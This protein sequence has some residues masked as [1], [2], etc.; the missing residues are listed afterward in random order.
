MPNTKKSLSLSKEKIKILLLEGLHNNALQLFDENGYNN[1]E[2]HKGSLNKSELI[3]QIKDVHLLGIRSKTN[4]TND[5]LKYA[6]KL[7][8]IGCYSIGTNQVDLLSAKLH[9]IPVFNAPFSNTRSVAELV[10]AECIFLIRGIPEKNFAA[11]N[12]VWLKR[13]F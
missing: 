8:A 5:I 1:V 7:I 11:H 12:E 4:I 9:G 13:C 6:N 3:E 2:Y 10:I